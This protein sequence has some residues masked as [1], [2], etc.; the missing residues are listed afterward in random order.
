MLL[1]ESKAL[2][3]GVLAPFTI[4]LGNVSV[5]LRKHGR[6][7][8]IMHSVSVLD[9]MVRFIYLILSHLKDELCVKKGPYTV[10]I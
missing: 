6:L 5:V 8:I 7:V 3:V 2:I 9:K 1:Q 10:A 4:V